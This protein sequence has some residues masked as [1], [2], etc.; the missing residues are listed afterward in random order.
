MGKIRTI[1]L[2]IEQQKALQEGYQLGK[3]HAF[4]R[5]C[6]L[7]LLKSEGRTSKEVSCIIK[8]NE[9]SVNK[10]LDGYESEG[11]EGLTTKPGRGR[12]QVFDQGQDEARVREVVQK[13]RQRL[14]GAKVILEKE[15]NKQFSLKTLKRF[16]KSLDPK[17]N[18]V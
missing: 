5:R 9:I 3:T 12:K 4:R 6:Q 16:L 8:M 14:A 18:I 11:I 1:E 7:I 17:I 15:L 2:T 13:E 10:W